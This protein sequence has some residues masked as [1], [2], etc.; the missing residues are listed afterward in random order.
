MWVDQRSIDEFDITQDVYT[1]A[2]GRLCVSSN[3]AKY[4]N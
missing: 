3:V 4:L 1:F 2:A